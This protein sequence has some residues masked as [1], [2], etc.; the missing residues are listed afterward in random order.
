MKLEIKPLYLELIAVIDDLR[1]KIESHTSGILSKRD[2]DLIQ[3]SLRPFISIR[4]VQIFLE[5]C[6]R[7]VDKPLDFSATRDFVFQKEEPVVLSF[8]QAPYNKAYGLDAFVYEI[9]EPDQYF[10]E[11]FS[12]SMATSINI[13]ICSHGFDQYPTC[14]ALFPENFY[15]TRSFK[16]GFSVFY[17]VSVFERRFQEFGRPTLAQFVDEKS[18]WRLKRIPK[19]MRQRAFATWHYLHEHFH[20]T[21]TLPLVD[22]LKLKSTRKAAAIEE[23]RVDVLSILE[24]LRSARLGFSDGFIY[25][26]LILFERLIRYS[27]HSDPDENYDAKSSYVLLGYLKEAGVVTLDEVMIDLDRRNLQEAL[28][29]Y[30]QDIENLELDIK[31][32]LS[33]SDEDLKSVRRNLV[34]F[35]DRNAAQGILVKNKF[36]SNV[37]ERIREAV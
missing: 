3:T 4:T 26:E 1:S 33:K 21:G 24:C 31:E 9:E 13:L 36:F 30:V 6:E 2:H 14:V 29:Q 20:S 23:S 27:I 28:E 34:E 7:C 12:A 8:F 18:F 37:R 22:Y 17:F 5:E 32:A 15:S 10:G 35:V 25:A 19:K 16:D 11:K